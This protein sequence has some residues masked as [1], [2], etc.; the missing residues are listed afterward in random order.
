MKR[1]DGMKLVGAG[2]WVLD[3][4]PPPSYEDL[5]VR[6]EMLL[7]N[8]E[9]YGQHRSGCQRIRLLPNGGQELDNL[10]D[11]D[12]GWEDFNNE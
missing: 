3:R 9:W 4:D 12:C 11:C 8:L 5:L 7:A 1:S 6:I 2:K 10:W